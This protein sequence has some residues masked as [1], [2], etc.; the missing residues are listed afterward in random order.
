MRIYFILLKRLSFLHFPLLIFYK[1]QLAL[2]GLLT[3]AVEVVVVTAVE[4]A[5]HLLA[6]WQ[7]GNSFKTLKRINK[8][9]AYSFTLGTCKDSANNERGGKD[10]T[11][12]IMLFV[13]THKDSPT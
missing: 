13:T 3:S 9:R 5:V 11:T 2:V 12:I 1:Y 4:V 6:N 7:L 10:A 8:N